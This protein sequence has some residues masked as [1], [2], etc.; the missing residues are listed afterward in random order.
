MAGKHTE[1]RWNEYGFDFEFLAAYGLR[2]ISAEEA[3]DKGFNNASEGIYIPYPSDKDSRIRWYRTG[4]A[5]QTLA[6][7]YGQRAGTLPAIYTPPTISQAH[8]ED[9]D[10][11]LI[12]TEGE[13]KAIAVDMIA[14]QEPG[15]QKPAIVPVSVSGVYNWQ[16]AKRG[17]DIIPDLQKLLKSGRKTILAFDMDQLT[18]PMVAQGMQ[19]LS[20]KLAEFGCFAQIATW[21]GAEG[22]GIDDYL[23]STAF[24]RRQ[25]MLDL[26]ENAA[27][28]GQAMLVLQMNEQFIYDMAQSQV[29]NCLTGQYIPTSAFKNDY[30]TATIQLAGP[31][32]N[33]KPTMRRLT[34]GQYW[35][36]SPM[37]A[38]CDGKRFVP[39]AERLVPSNDMTG[40]VYLN[41][42]MGW[43]KG[44]QLRNLKPTQ[45]DVT[46]FKEYLQATFGNEQCVEA[47]MEPVS[48]LIQRLAWMFQ[49]PTTKH[50]TWVYL[51]GKPR[52]G[53][54]LLINIIATLVGRL[55]TSHIDENMLRSSFT[56][57]L[58]EKLLVAFDDAAVVER[59]HIKQVLKRLTTETHTQVNK[60]YEKSYGAEN[61]V[62]FLFATNSLDPLLDHD[63]R[64]ALVLE[65]KCTWDDDKWKEFDAWIA[66]PSSY[67]AIL[68]YLMHEVV[69][70][71][72]FATC[73][74]PKTATR[75]LVCEAAETKWDAF[76][77]SLASPLGAQWLS[78]ASGEPR[79]LKPTVFTPEML[80]S[81]FVLMHGKDDKAEAIAGGT[82][83]AKLNRFGYSKCRPADSSDKRH[84][85]SFNGVITNAWCYETD[86]LDAKL[87]QIQK[88][89]HRLHKDYPELFSWCSPV[90]GKF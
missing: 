59:R 44:S 18:N 33:G 10:I 55:Y 32:K 38:V 48:F 22:K 66:L 86:W 26:I 37:R 77:N 74:P 56:E 52:Q 17:V 14:N 13:F 82:L 7:K 30:F 9:S 79:V 72:G 31:P 4:F 57:W 60:K 49:R 76:L 73:T 88:E 68:H 78:P 43:G 61:Y 90:K 58:A 46:L 24:L 63:D 83:T 5:A 41:T 2:D 8:L 67:A 53:K 64:R 45:G 28:S 65:A 54:S 6:G 87:E 23:C 89:L 51:I 34:H 16:S 62:M 19:R 71:E 25:R 11:P 3:E 50:P 84:R 15:L 47:G 80:V 27:F 81:M 69:I 39:G 85:L 36:E 35:L 21:P 20:N 12:I 1:K 70:D 42:W 75:E 29:Y 40:R